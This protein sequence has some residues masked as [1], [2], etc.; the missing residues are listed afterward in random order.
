MRPPERCAAENDTRSRGHASRG[1]PCA[2]RRH[3]RARRPAPRAYGVCQA[4]RSAPI[5]RLHSPVRF[6]QLLGRC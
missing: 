6:L 3:A 2:A 1:M 5:S 4:S